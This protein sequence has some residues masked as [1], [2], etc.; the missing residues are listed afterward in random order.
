MADIPDF[1]V[2]WWCLKAYIAKIYDL[3]GDMADVRNA[4]ECEQMDDTEDL[5]TMSA[6]Y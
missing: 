2:G 6:E 3:G 4:A 1:G 5:S